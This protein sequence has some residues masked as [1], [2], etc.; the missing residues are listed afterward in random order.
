MTL[1][2]N[3]ILGAESDSDD[4]LHRYEE[5]QRGGKKVYME[6]DEYT[7]VVH[8]Y[9][10]KSDFQ[11]ALAAA[12]TALAIYPGDDDIMMLQSFSFI[13]LKRYD[14]ATE[15]LDRLEKQIPPDNGAIA[16]LR[17]MILIGTGKI[18][19]GMAIINSWL[20]RC[21]NNEQRQHFCYVAIDSMRTAKEFKLASLYAG[22]LCHCESENPEVHLLMAR[23]CNDADRIKDAISAY[24]DVLKYEME[25]EEEIWVELG[26]VYERNNQ[27]DKAM[28][29]YT[30]AI[31]VNPDNVTGYLHKATLYASSDQNAELEKALDVLLKRFPD[32]APAWYSKGRCYMD[33]QKPMP[34]LECFSSAIGADPYYADAYFGLAMVLMPLNKTNHQMEFAKRAIALYP[35][36]PGFYICLSQAY[37]QKMQWKNAIATLE[38]CLMVDRKAVGAWVLLS[39]A[40]LSH[41]D[42]P[43]AIRTLRDALEYMPYEPRLLCHL[44]LTLYKHNYFD[45]CADVLDSLWETK[46]SAYMHTFFQGCDAKTNKDFMKLIKKKPYGKA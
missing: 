36:N 34:A 9:V 22:L 24:K 7:D 1:D 13:N 21:E 29:A 37:T 35:Y 16:Q 31:A 42:F 18:A 44:A 15:V 12:K 5:M 43:A 46:D 33:M 4:L 3:S 26:G 40:H 20:D 14:E 10:R 38:H 11:Q 6:S 41:K 23:C 19:D 8:S 17:A 32:F 39:D 30:K 2:I 45:I 28:K 25:R 27:P